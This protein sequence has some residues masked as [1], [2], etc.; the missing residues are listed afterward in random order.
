ML[1]QKLNHRISLSKKWALKAR[2]PQESGVYNRLSL[3]KTIKTMKPM[4]HHHKVTQ[5][6]GSVKG[7]VTITWH[8]ALIALL[9]TAI[10]A[11][12]MPLDMYYTYIHFTSSKLQDNTVHRRS[13]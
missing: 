9:A 2:K 12:T 10:A 6:V 11:V 3:V 13:L 7:G 8:K 4:S 1:F 5:S